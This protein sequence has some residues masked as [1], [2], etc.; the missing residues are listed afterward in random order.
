VAAVDESKIFP[1]ERFF[2]ALKPGQ[3]FEV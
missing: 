1:R 3:V 2:V